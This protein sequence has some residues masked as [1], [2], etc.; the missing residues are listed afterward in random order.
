[1]SDEWC[2]ALI[3]CVI[4]VHP[5]LANLHVLETGLDTVYRGKGA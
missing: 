2:L 3:D 1:M 4:H 5:P